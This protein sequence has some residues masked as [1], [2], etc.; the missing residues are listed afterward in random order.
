MATAS[1]SGVKGKIATST[2]TGGSK[3]TIAELRDWNLSGEH[4]T[5]DATSKDSSGARESIAGITQW[6]GSAN[7]LYAATTS[8]THLFD[9]LNNRAKIDFEFYPAG[10]SS[11]FP[12]FSGTGWITSWDF[13]SP[14]EDVTDVNADFEITGALTKSTSS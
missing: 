12:I 9:T 14:N 11:S 13:N 5:F 1:I 7:H 10:T 4:G 3:F 2:S 6:S 8:Q